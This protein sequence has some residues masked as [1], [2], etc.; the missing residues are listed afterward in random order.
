MRKHPLIALIAF[1]FVAA[2]I[3]IGAAGASSIN[4]VPV[5]ATAHLSKG[6]VEP[7]TMP[8]TS[9]RWLAATVRERAYAEAQLTALVAR[10]KYSPFWQ[11][12]AADRVAIHDGGRPAGI[13]LPSRWRVVQQ[14]ERVP[15]PFARAQP[16][17]QQ[18]RPHRPRQAAQAEQA[19]QAGTSRTSR[20]SRTS[21]AESKTHKNYTSH[22]SHKNLNCQPSCGSGSDNI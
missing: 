10:E 18:R 14:A 1:T 5:R 20:T 8:A 22:K 4:A 16:L 3:F 17:E 12:L 9:L 15:Q 7:S 11:G 2:S 19:A 6:G 21:D 13:L